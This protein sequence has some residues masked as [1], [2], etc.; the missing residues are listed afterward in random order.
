VSLAGRAAGKVRRELAR[1]VGSRSGRGAVLLYHRVA[2]DSDDPWKLAV[3]PERFEAHMELLRDEFHP[4]PLSE[5]VAAARRRQIPPGAVAVTFDDGYVDNLDAALPVLERTG[6][7]AT[8]F[9]ATEYV[10]SSRPF[11]WDELH[12]LILGGYELPDE[13]VIPVGASE[14]RIGLN[15]AEEREL[16]HEELRDI[17]RAGPPQRVERVLAQLRASAGLDAAAPTGTTRPLTREELARLARSE[18][19]EI[20]A[21][22]RSHP[23]FSQVPLD[24]LEQEVEGS[25]ADLAEWL[26]EVPM[27]FSYPFG[28]HGPA[29]R[30]V[31]R[32]AGFDAAVSTHPSPI[33]W[34]R[35]PAEFGRM[36]VDDEAPEWLESRLHRLVA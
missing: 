9:V 5:L 34:L 2:G 27:I 36:W 25:R 6:V 20:G 18:L 11:W 16:A 12:S 30:R 15:T 32:R 10:A 33:T 24:A 8:V 29:A 3:S 4:L 1:I 26:G 7:P 17:L 23:A 35:D 21:H 13:L 28:V 14:R 19:V 31:V 22:S